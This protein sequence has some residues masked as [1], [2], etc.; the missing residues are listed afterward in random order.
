MINIH[1]SILFFVKNT[2]NTYFLGFDNL[3]TSKD[4]RSV[5]I[6]IGMHGE[7]S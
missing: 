6:L 5:D 7:Y 3:S 1:I 4:T 2:N